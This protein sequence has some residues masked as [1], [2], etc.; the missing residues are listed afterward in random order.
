MPTLRELAVIAAFSAGYRRRA[1]RSAA[2]AS[3]AACLLSGIAWQLI[4]TTRA[5]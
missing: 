5:T 1:L 3:V 2:V 4:A